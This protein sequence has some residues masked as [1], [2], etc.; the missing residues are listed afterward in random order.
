MNN[1]LITLDTDWAPDFIIDWVAEILISYK[2]KATWFVTHPSPAISR[3]R[4]HLNLFELGIHPNFLP[5]S[6]HGE[7]I[8]DV[9]NYCLNIVPDAT[10]M[11]THCLFQSSPLFVKIIQNTEIKID[12]SLFLLG[13]PHLKPFEYWFNKKQ[14]IRIPCYWEDDYEMQLPLP[15]WQLSKKVIE[16]PGLKVFNFHPI[17][18]YLN[19]STMSSY[20]SLKKEFPFIFEATP[21][22][23]QKFIE[24]G[25]GTQTI[26]LTILQYLSSLN[27]SFLVQDIYQD[28]YLNKIK[29]V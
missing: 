21:S 28:Y 29:E 10:C 25:Y 20:H 24:K 1:I 19:S 5:N 4:E 7:T 14:L 2:V 3:L 15:S 13:V 12:L 9:L 11:R 23:T 6:S 8:N 16:Q 18:I 22:S 17:H 27:T 26:F